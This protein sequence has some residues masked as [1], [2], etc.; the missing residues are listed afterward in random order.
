MKSLLYVICLFYD[1]KTTYFDVVRI[2]VMKMCFHHLEDIM[3]V[4]NRHNMIRLRLRKQF[5]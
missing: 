1:F 2:Y 3:P 5:S 4:F